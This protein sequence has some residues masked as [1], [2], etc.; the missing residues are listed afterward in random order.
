MLRGLRGEQGDNLVCV[1]QGQDPSLFLSECQP[2]RDN[3]PLLPVQ[4]VISL[5]TPA[6]L[7][8]TA[9]LPSVELADTRVE[10]RSGW[11]SLVWE[12]SGE[13]AETLL[14]RGSA[15]VVRRA[16]L[17]LWS[18]RSQRRAPTLSG[19]QRGLK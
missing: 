19:H 7:S 13:P 17:S 1:V 3:S 4:S 8:S 11:P 9:L 18:V 12:L 10:V 6:I 5:V 2:W 16:T 14:S 15:S